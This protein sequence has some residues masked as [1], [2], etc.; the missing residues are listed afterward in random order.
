MQDITIED[1]ERLAASL[2]ES[3][4]R[5]REK[6]VRLITA[7]ARIVAAREPGAF[8]RPRPLEVS[9]EEGHWDTNYPPKMT[10]KDRRGPRVID[11]TT[12]ETE[13]VPTTGGYYYEWRR[14]TT[15]RGLYVGMDGTLYG[16][17]EEGTG[18]HG[19][20]AAYPGDAGVECA[21]SWDPIKA[22][23]VPLDHL[24]EAEA[25]MRRLAFPRASAA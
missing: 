21:I 24:R 25:T 17:T 13:D 2:S 6:L 5:E 16:S 4:A 12:R 23:I 15:D 18:R 20:F 11:I 9:D 8:G 22:D 14:V 7:E 3:E 19:Q 1:V 10:Y